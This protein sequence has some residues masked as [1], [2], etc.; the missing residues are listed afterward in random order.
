MDDTACAA[1]AAAARAI[2]DP[3]ADSDP[4]PDDLAALA[5]ALELAGRPASSIS[6]AP[7]PIPTAA[8]SSAPCSATSSP[9]ATA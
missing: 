1:A 7:W 9:P 4:G 5:G 3:R 6:P 8:T 2:D